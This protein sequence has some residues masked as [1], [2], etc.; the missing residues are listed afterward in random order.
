MPGMQQ[1]D[2]Q[3]VGF[4]GMQ[5]SGSAFS[6]TKGS[7]ITVKN[8]SGKTLYTATGVRNAD[9]VEMINV[10]LDGVVYDNSIFYS[11]DI[12]LYGILNN[13]IP[14]ADRNTFSTSMRTLKKS[15]KEVLDSINNAF[16]D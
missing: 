1:P 2:A 12:K 10:V 5:Q 14:S 6:I 13:T 8:S 4:G 3:T 7:T 11:S 15:A 9:S 16:A